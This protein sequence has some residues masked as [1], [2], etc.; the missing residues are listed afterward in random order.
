M[1]NKI[2]ELKIKGAYLICFEPR[3]DPRGFFARL[4]DVNMLRSLGLNAD[5][6][7]CNFS[8]SHLAGTFRGLH[9]Q[10]APYQENKLFTLVKGAVTSIILDLRP[11]SP[12]YKQFEEVK[13][14]IWDRNSLY[15]PE[16]CAHGVYTLVDDVRL[17]YWATCE[18]K[19]EAECGIRW[20][21]PL[22]GKCIPEPK[23]ISGKDM[24]W[25]DYDGIRSHKKSD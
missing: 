10:I 25:S 15:V 7:Q 5:F 2:E 18:Y 13:F 1:S 8:Y 20:N 19:P 12:T 24:S 16:G 9:Y 23:V 11:E 14:G 3:Q 21:D 4:W 17:V 22:L 6:K